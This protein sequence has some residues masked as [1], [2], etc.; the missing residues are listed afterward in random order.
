MEF[1]TAEPNLRADSNVADVSQNQISEVDLYDELLAFSDLSPEEQEAATV[2]AAPGNIIDPPAETPA[3]LEAPPRTDDAFFF[4]PPQ[5]SPAQEAAFELTEERVVETVEV[6]A[7]EPARE[8][9]L[10]SPQAF[11]FDDGGNADFQMSDIIRVTGPLP[12]FLTKRDTASVLLVCAE[13]GSPADNEEMFCIA[14]GGL[15][16]EAEAAVVLSCDECGST[17]ASDEIFC[18]SCGSVMPGA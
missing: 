12:G 8:P 5:D 14:C 17:V 6:E 16:E 11:A 18:P 15:L 2:R 13:C 3:E 10:D 7:P 9:T 4:E 1:K